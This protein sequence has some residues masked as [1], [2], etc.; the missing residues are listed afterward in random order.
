[1]GSNPPRG[2]NAFIDCSQSPRSNVVA[3]W[4]A[5]CRIVRR[6]GCVGALCAM[7]TFPR[8]AKRWRERGRY[9]VLC[10]PHRVA[11][12]AVMRLALIVATIALVPAS[13]AAQR[14]TSI[15]AGVRPRSE[16]HS[17]SSSPLRSAETKGGTS[18]HAV[19]MANGALIGAGIGIAVGLVAS[20]IVNSQNADHSEDA[21]TYILLPAFG[22]FL[23][24][25]IGGIVGWRRGG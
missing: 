24:L 17:S 14:T 2:S 19:G 1:M 23:G 3:L 9:Y 15:R 13:A 4:F 12:S 11:V 6:S 16:I 10:L 20:P 21:M 22:A 5:A 18:G 25:I 8:R 7:E